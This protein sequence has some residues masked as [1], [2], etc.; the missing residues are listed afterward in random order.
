MDLIS[1]ASRLWYLALHLALHLFV[2]FFLMQD[3]A[4]YYFPV[5][6]PRSSYGAAVVALPL[7]H[8]C[9]D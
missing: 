8:C 5:H 3:H 7:W 6:T 9:I 1:G 2:C 4:H